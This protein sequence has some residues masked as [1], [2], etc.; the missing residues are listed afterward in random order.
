M[1]NSAFLHEVFMQTNS[2][3]WDYSVQFWSP[4]R[5]TRSPCNDLGVIKSGGYS[6]HK[7]RGCPVVTLSA[8]TSVVAICR[9][10]HLVT[11]EQ[12]GTERESVAPVCIPCQL[13]RESVAPID[14]S[15]E[16]LPFF[17]LY[18]AAATALLRMRSDAKDA[19]SGAFGS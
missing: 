13:P 5:C 15:P 11:T 19:P 3:S 8:G 2:R 14:I 1:D 4:S 6:A 9:A 10:R 7:A 12:T 17:R 16:L 18:H